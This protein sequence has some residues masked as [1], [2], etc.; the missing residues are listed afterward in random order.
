[1]HP[2]RRIKA[3][4]FVHCFKR[5]AKRLPEEQQMA[6]QKSWFS[7]RAQWT[8]II[9]VAIAM[10]TALGID[11]L[12]AGLNKL[13]EAA[14][15]GSLTE[16]LMAILVLL[17]SSAGSSTARRRSGGTPRRTLPSSPRSEARQPHD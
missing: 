7:S 6:L 14:A 11:P 4:Y 17:S 15:G 9:G 13:A 1:M 10:A 3:A 12:V 8:R 16:V 2:I 5:A